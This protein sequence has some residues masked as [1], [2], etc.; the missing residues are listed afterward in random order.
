MHSTL[1][2]HHESTEFFIPLQSSW[3]CINTFAPSLYLS[4]APPYFSAQNRMVQV[5]K[6]DIAI[7]QCEVNGDV[8]IEVKWLKAGKHE[9]NPSTNYRVSLKQDSIPDG[10]AAE[11][12]ISNVDSSDSGPYF[13][14]AR[15]AYGRDQQLIQLQV[16]EPPSPPASLEAV[17]VSSRSVNLKWQPRGTSTTTGSSSDPNDVVRYI[18][19]YREL[20]RQWDQMELNETPQFTALIENLKPATRYAFRVVAVGTAG[21]SLPSQELIIK[22]DPQRP[23]GPPLSLSA[24]PMSS[25]EVLVTW[26]PPLAETKNGEILGYNIGYKSALS[27]SNSYNFTTFSGNG[28]E[29]TGELLLADLSKFHR[30]TITVQAF[31]QIGPGPLAEPISV[32]TLE[33]VPGQPPED[34][35]CASLTSESLQISWQPPQSQFMNGLLQGYKLFFEP[36]SE[37]WAEEV[38]TRKTTSQTTVLNHL[39]KY[40]NYR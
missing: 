13:C 38:E 1:D 27:N 37:H 11:A 6:G 31:N 7:L 9:L 14:Q 25:S 20:D 34:V 22:T 29:G 12:Q 40:T 35:R 10:V 17:T 3:K 2:Y 24:R 23:N 32:Q 19:E 15:N 18:V 5:K 21:K 16:Q 30:Y 33:D 26:A 36:V 28:E 39:K 8:P 4:T